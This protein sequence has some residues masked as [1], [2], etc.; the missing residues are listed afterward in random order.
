M[1]LL[2]V[3]PYLPVRGVMAAR[4]RFWHLLA[5]LAP[6]HEVTLLAFVDPEDAGR[7]D[8]P[9]GLAGVD[10]IAKTPYRPEDPLALLPRTVAG[11]YADPA[12]RAAVAARLAAGRFD[13]VQ[14]EF[15]EMAQCIPGP[16]ARSILTVHQISFAQQADAWRAD[17]GKLRRGAVFLHRYLRELDFELRAV[18]AV[19]HVV[20]MSAEDAARLRR[21]APDL[22]ISVSPCGVDCA[23]FR[24]RDDAPE[25][26]LLFVGHFGHPPN[27]DAVGFLVGDIAPR[28]GRPVRIRIVG[29]GVIPEVAR[30]ASPTVEIVGAVDDVRPH[31]AAARVVVAPVRFGTGMRGKVLE[32]LAMGRPVVTT[33][34]GAEGLGATAGRDLLVA[35]GAADFAAAIRRVLDEPGVASALGAGGRALAVARFDWDAIAAAHEEIYETVV[36]APARAAQGR[37]APARLQ[38]VATSLGYLP[39]VGLGFAFLLARATRAHAARV[40]RRRPAAL[41]SAPAALEA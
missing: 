38:R 17:G 16:A 20:T 41:A 10:R 18:R 29:R 14:Y 39:G 26:D 32:A 23:A 24:P 7:D 3:V 15:S 33:T 9:P 28:F 36:R 21:F 34:V 37:A 4:E 27:V 22:P 12:L 40:R 31:L 5:R 11:G 13:V 19:D 8:L 1:R 30:R 25:V 2:W 6:R 35:D